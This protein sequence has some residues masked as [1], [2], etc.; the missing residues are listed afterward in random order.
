MIGDHLRA[1]SEKLNIY[2]TSYDN[3]IILGDFIIEIEEQQINDFCDNQSLKSFIRQPLCYKSPSNPTCVDLILTN[4]PQK[5]QSFCLVETGLSDF[6]LMTVTVMRN[7]FKKLKP[8][9]INYRSY[10]YFSNEA[11]RESL[12]MN[13]QKRFSLI[14]MTAWKG[15]LNRHGPRKRKL[16]RGNQMPFITKDLLKAI[17]KRSRLS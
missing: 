16:A 17:M 15:F 11:Y 8:R 12:Y 14:M 4:A 10:K 6:H 1:L 7:I 3:F 9:T 13:S 2:S 5:F